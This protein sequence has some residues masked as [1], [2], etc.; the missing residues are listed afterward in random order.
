[1]VAASSGERHLTV[2]MFLAKRPRSVAFDGAKSGKSL[3][4]MLQIFL[5]DLAGRVG[6]K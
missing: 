4:F 1:M 3:H 6:I 5:G 2:Q